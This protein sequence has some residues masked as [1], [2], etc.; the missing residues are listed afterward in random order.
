MKV[1]SWAF[2]LSVLIISPL[3][4]DLYPF[5]VFPMFSDNC[6]EHLTLEITDAE[7]KRLNPID[8]GLFKV[9]MANRDQ[10][11]G[12]NFGPSYF[13]RN[14]EIQESKMR[15]FLK[16]NYP[17]KAYPIVIKYRVRGF[18]ETTGRMGDIVG[19]TEIKIDFEDST[20]LAKR[21]PDIVK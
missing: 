3:F 4:T 6:S 19:P 12:Y 17:D 8:Y 10:R 21:T 16:K 11:Y 5:S 9:Q 2:M 18:D 7:S 1:F 20:K 15:S 14:Q 13:D